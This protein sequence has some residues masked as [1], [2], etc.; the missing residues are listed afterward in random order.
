MLNLTYLRCAI[1]LSAKPKAATK[2]IFS[3][4]LHKW[5]GSGCRGVPELMLVIL[6][7]QVEIYHPTWMHGTEGIACLAHGY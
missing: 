6:S 5:S 4:I 1:S 3:L 2:H 7:I